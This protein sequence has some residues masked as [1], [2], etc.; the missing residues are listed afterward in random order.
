MSAFEFQFVPKFSFNSEDTV[1]ND[2]FFK[3]HIK[4]KKK[5]FKKSTELYKHEAK[6]PYME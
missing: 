1:S 5:I 3:L 4:N 6:N 2:F